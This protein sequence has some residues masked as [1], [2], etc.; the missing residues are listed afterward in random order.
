EAITGTKYSDL[1]SENSVLGKWLR[2]RP[3][4]VT[5]NDIIFVHGGI[6]SDLVH[7][8][9]NIKQINQEFSDSI[10]GRDIWSTGENEELI[11]LAGDNGPLWYRGYFTDSTFTESKLDS[12]LLFY[13][14]AHIVVG[15][16]THKNIKSLFNNKILGIDAGIMYSQP[17]AMLIYREGC[18]YKGSLS[19]KRDKL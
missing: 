4:I 18:F 14:K 3:V 6:S 12:I 19:G 13:D 1:F 16:S 7:R 15:H 9:L 17:G 2:S 11:F 8:N 10:V 5:I